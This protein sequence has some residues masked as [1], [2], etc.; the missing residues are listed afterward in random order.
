MVRQARI[1]IAAGVK[2]ATFCQLLPSLSAPAPENLLLERASR[3][4]VLQLAMPVSDEQAARHH[5]HGR[6]LCS[7]N[8]V[9]SSL[10]ARFPPPVWACL[11]NSASRPALNYRLRSPC[12]LLLV[13]PLDCR[14][15]MG[16]F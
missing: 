12:G 9:S 5:R 11:C 4:P 2:S 14:I 1:P 3:P 6:S 7:L 8:A 13:V 10:P 15:E 16:C